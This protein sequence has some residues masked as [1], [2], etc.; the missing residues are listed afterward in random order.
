MARRIESLS[1]QELR[2][3]LALGDGRMNKQIGAELGISE[4]T[5]KVHMKSILRK[6]GLPRRTQAALV[7]Q[8]VLK[9]EPQALQGLQDAAA[10]LRS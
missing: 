3:L 8:R 5:V 10:R 2:I 4:G 7:A 6:L 1:R 9:A